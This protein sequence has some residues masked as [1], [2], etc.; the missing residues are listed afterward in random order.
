VIIRAWVRLARQATMPVTAPDAVR[1]GVAETSSTRPSGSVASTASGAST[2]ATLEVRAIKNGFSV[3]PFILDDLTHMLR[4]KR[5]FNCA[6][7]IIDEVD[8]RPL[9]RIVANLLVRLV[10]ARSERGSI[11]LTSNEHV[12]DWPEIFAG[13]EILTTAIL[14]RLLHPVSPSTVEATDPAS[15]VRSS[16][17]SPTARLPRLDLKATP[18]LDSPRCGNL[19]VHPPRE[20]GCAC[21]PGLERQ[22]LSLADTRPTTWELATTSAPPTCRVA[23]RPRCPPPG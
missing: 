11:V 22:D 17:P 4:A 8:F 6:L 12:R 19:P 16:G 2:A 13:D 20:C 21:T 14:D 10:S 23:K 15:W 7:P 1:I 5:Y 3:V 9:D 18:Q